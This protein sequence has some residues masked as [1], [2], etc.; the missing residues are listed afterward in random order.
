[1]CIRDRLW[2]PLSSPRVEAG[3]DF[4]HGLLAG[5]RD[6][7]GTDCEDRQG[8]ALEYRGRE[9]GA[10]LH[11]LWVGSLACQHDS[12]YVP[13]LDPL[14]AA[15]ALQKREHLRHRG[16]ERTDQPWILEAGNSARLLS[17]ENVQLGRRSLR[18]FLDLR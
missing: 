4:A 9:L 10:H 5:R 3:K 11:S 1:M 16:L 14:H 17:G 2:I 8:K 15:D 18:A 6:I 7:L 13:G 12:G